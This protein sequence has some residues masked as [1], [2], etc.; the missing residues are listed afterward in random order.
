[1]SQ[2]FHQGIYSFPNAYERSVAAKPPAEWMTREQGGGFD[3]LPPPPPTTVFD[4][5][6]MLTELINLPWRKPDVLEDHQIQHT[7]TLPQKQQ[8]HSAL[9][10]NGAAEEVSY[11]SVPNET[12]IFQF[13]IRG[14]FRFICTYF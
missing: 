11:V 13:Q 2:G 12:H 7:Y 3:A 14:A 4:A 10:L 6:G 8:L 1:M 5:G 9:P